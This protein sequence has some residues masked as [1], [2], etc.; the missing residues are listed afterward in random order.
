MKQWNYTQTN[1]HQ[2]WNTT[3]WFRTHQNLSL[4]NQKNPK[5]CAYNHI[6]KKLQPKTVSLTSLAGCMLS[7]HL[8]SM[9]LCRPIYKIISWGNF[10]HINHKESPPDLKYVSTLPCET[11][12]LQLL[13]ILMALAYCMCY[14]RIHLA[15]YE[16]NLIVLLWIPWL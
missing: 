6:P 10:V 8:W 3:F 2:P 7:L 11:W 5:I 12:K 13:L 16:A 4:E 15:R 14:L 9:S 1:W